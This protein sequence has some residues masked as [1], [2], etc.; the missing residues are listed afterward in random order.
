M[1]GLSCSLKK[2]EETGHINGCKISRTAPTISHL[3]FADDS[4]LFFRANMGEAQRIKNILNTYEMHSGQ[5]VNFQKS[6]IF[7]SS[8]VSQNTQNEVSGILGVWNDLTVSKY[9]G[10]PSLIGRAKK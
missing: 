9:L 6:G 5:A 4:F 1:E 8:N 2:A 10:L 3:L 7:F